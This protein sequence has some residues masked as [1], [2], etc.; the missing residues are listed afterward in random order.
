MT[1]T[2]TPLCVVLC[3]AVCRYHVTFV[4]DDSNTYAYLYLD[5]GY[6]KS[7]TCSVKPTE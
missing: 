5:G 4:Y 7:Y 3:R 6:T 1:L 2:L